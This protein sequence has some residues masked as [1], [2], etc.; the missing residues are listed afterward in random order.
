MT[1]HD[2]PALLPRLALLLAGL[3]LVALAGCAERDPDPDFGA[4][5]ADW[6]RAASPDFHG[7]YVKARALTS[8]RSCHAFDL[9]GKA[10]V[11]GCYGC[12]DGPGGHPAGWA[13]PQA[14]GAEASTNGSAACAICHGDDFR[15]GWSGVS[16]Y[17][18]HNG[19]TG[20]H[21]DGW[22]DPAQHGV[23]VRGNGVSSCTLCHGADY[24]GGTSGTSCFTCH[25]GPG[26]HPTGWAQPAQ[27]GAE[28]ATNGPAS[29]AACHGA[30]YRGGWSTVSCYACHA[31]GPNG[32]H[33]VGW[34][35]PAQHGATVRVSGV[36]SCTACHGA[37]YLGGT[38]GVSCFTC[39][40]GPGGHPTA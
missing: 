36:S 10:D 39:H 28:A 27:H 34:A 8:C 20:A 22:A 9:R 14:H 21:P 19:P 33:P 5:P 11:P 13:A 6:S 15:G 12:H 32:A 40:D 35:N 1:R 25:D 2:R 23:F 38:S 24:L 16:C 31:G 17:T 30:D 3:G 26:G 29:C 18:C 4:H 7:E 37:N